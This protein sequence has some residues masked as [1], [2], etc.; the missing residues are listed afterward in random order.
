[1]SAPVHKVTFGGVSIAVF[2][3]QSEKFGVS[4]SFALNKSYKDKNDKWINQVVYLNNTADLINVVQCVQEVLDW[5]YRGN[6]KTPKVV[7]PTLEQDTEL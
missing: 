3:K 6:A 7:A 2:E 5:R 4:N 1:M